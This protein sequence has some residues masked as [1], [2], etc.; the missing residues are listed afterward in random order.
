MR[1]LLEKWKLDAEKVKC[2][3]GLIKDRDMID[4]YDSC[5][6]YLNLTDRG[7]LYHV[8]DLALDLFAEV[9]VFIYDGYSTNYGK[10][11]F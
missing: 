8:T 7:S 2:L 5:E 6:V 9:E 1:K 3:N 4:G 11:R 10:S